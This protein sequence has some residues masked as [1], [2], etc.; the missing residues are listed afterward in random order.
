MSKLTFKPSG[1]PEKRGDGGADLSQVDAV[2]EA[3]KAHAGRECVLV[4]K[5]TVPVGTN[6]VL[7]SRPLLSWIMVRSAPQ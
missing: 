1:M 4:A 3:V 7:A 5:S 6:G 2:A